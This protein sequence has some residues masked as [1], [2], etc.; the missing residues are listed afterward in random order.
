MSCLRGVP[1]QSMGKF[2]SEDSITKQ[3]LRQGRHPRC[4]PIH[5]LLTKCQRCDWRSSR[6][7][8]W[9][10][11]PTSTNATSSIKINRNRRKHHSFI[12][13]VMI[14]HM[15]TPNRCW[16]TN[17]A[18]AKKKSTMWSFR[19]LNA[20]H[21]VHVLGNTCSQINKDCTENSTRSR[22][23]LMFSSVHKLTKRPFTWRSRCPTCHTGDPMHGWWQRID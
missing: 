19:I 7:H 14:S 9:Q 4:E 18:C 11:L 17:G 15:S 3:F 8:I 23:S 20:N 13:A 12:Q 21:N 1:A 6:P 2:F 10:E 5:M 22:S 16:R